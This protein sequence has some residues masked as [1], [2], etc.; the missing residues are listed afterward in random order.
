MKPTRKIR[1]KIQSEIP[2]S[3]EDKGK[4]KTITLSTQ[5]P[6]TKWDAAVPRKFKKEPLQL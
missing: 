1:S 5:G 6:W 2:E 3:E 4:T